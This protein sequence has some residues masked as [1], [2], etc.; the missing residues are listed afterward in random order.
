M[1]K[2]TLLPSYEES[3]GNIVPEQDFPVETPKGQKIL[4]QLTVTRT[5]QIL[6]VIEESIYP[7]VEHQAVCGIAKT[8][9][10]LIPSD[11]MVSQ[12]ED[13]KSEFGF[14]NNQTGRIELPSFPSG[15]DVQR[16]QL[17]GPMNRLEFWKQ[18]GIVRELERLLHQRLNV[19]SQHQPPDPQ[20]KAPETR[21]LKHSKRGFF[22]R[23]SNNSSPQT[24]QPLDRPGVVAEEN[25]AQAQ[26]HVHANLEE[27]CL[28]TMSQFGLYE[29]MTRQCIVVRVNARY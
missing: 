12:G 21:P 27:L 2:D 17:E 13:T 1:S 6:S 8:T 7:R 22:S 3:I 23:R 26:V 29:T 14:E 28:R 20:L 19:S 10:A 5:Q 24:T 25:E 18:Q 11:A 9:V 15:E 16:V 4:D